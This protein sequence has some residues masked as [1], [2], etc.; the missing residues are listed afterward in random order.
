MV[1]AGADR[2]ER[3][4][5]PLITASTKSSIDQP[6]I[7]SSGSVEIFGTTKVPKSVAS[8]RPPARRSLSS[9]SAS[10]AAWQDA[11]PPA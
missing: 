11:Q 6:P 10:G 8:L 4:D 9:P 5:T 3:P 1:S 7:P 2:L